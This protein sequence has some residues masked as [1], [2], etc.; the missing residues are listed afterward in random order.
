MKAAVIIQLIALPAIM[1]KLTIQIVG[2]PTWTDAKVIGVRNEGEAEETTDA[3]DF[4]R[5]GEVARCLDNNY[6]W[7]EDCAGKPS[8]LKIGELNFEQ[9]T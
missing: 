1:A 2:N 7:T 6:A 9:D 8:Y 4:G 5:E 3:S